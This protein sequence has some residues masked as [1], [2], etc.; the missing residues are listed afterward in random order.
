[1]TYP[2]TIA[3]GKG[4]KE[5]SAEDLELHTS[6]RYSCTC[7]RTKTKKVDYKCSW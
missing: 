4:K 5:M 3:Q 6:I 7:M 2:I 1:M